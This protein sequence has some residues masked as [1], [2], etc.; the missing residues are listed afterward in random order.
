MKVSHLFKLLRDFRFL[1]LTQA[2]PFFS[3]AAKSSVIG[4]FRVAPDKLSND[5]SG[6]QAIGELC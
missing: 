6:W 1:G 3:Y 2:V 5:W 4:L